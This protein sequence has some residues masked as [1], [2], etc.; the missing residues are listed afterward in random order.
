MAAGKPVP[1]TLPGGTK[2]TGS[3]EQAER[4]GV[5]KPEPKKKATPTK[6]SD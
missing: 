3:K 4:L 1:F 5:A 6:K 2:V